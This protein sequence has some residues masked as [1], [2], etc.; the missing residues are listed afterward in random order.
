L[1]KVLAGA[2]VRNLA[3]VCPRIG[4]HTYLHQETALKRLE[5]LLVQ[6]ENA[7]VRES[8]V[9]VLQSMN[10]NGVL[11][12]VH[13]TGNSVTQAARI[14]SYW[15]EIARETKRRVK[16][17]LSGISQNR[18]DQAVGRLLRKCDN[19]FKVAFKGLS[20]VLSR[21]EGCVCLLDRYT[22]FGEDDD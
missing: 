14:M 16:L 11:E 3:V 6:L 13:V 8:V 22:W 12:I 15:L 17:K 5:T 4:F 10:E 1:S 18:T 20:L 21:G 9:Q 2:A 19:V 7:G